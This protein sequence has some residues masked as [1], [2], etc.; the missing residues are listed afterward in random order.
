VSFPAG[1]TTIQV[2]G[3][4]ILDLGGNPLNGSFVFTPVG[5][6][7]DPAA[8][9]LLEGSAVGQVIDGV[10]TPVTIPTTDAVV[11]SFTYTITTRLSTADESSPAPVTGVSIPASLGASVDISMLL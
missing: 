2:T 7:D 3:R 6:V 5:P 9:T 4:H 10:M 11:P 1:I 8:Q